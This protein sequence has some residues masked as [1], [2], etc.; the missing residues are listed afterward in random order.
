MIELRPEVQSSPVEGAVNSG[1]RTVQGLLNQEISNEDARREPWVG[2]LGRV[3]CE[4]RRPWYF[5]AVHLFCL[6][7]L[8]AFAQEPV[9]TQESA[10]YKNR[11]FRLHRI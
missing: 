3:A 7:G 1:V 5:A 10:E 9:A 2:E 8:A 11:R 4:N 6:L